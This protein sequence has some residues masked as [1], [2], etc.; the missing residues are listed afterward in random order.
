MG[1]SGLGAF[2]SP[3]AMTMTWLPRAAAAASMAAQLALTHSGSGTMMTEPGGARLY[4]IAR[5][6]DDRFAANPGSL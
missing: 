5:A 2:A 4:S 6:T 1:T 3:G